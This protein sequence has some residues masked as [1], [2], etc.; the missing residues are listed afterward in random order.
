MSALNNN[1]NIAFAEPNFLVSVQGPNDPLDGN[2]HGTHVSGTIG[3][4]GNNSTGVAGVNW[5]VQLV[6]L[7]FLPD[8]GSGTLAGAIAA[9]DYY[10][11]I[12]SKQDAGPGNYVATN[13]SWGGGGFSQSVLDSMVRGARQDVLFVAAAGNGGSDLIGDSRGR[14]YDDGNAKTSG[15][16]DYALI[17]DFALGDKIQVAKGGTYLFH[18]ISLKT[19]PGTGLYFDSKGNGAFDT[20]DEL[21]AVIQ[22]PQ[23]SN[24]NGLRPYLCV[25]LGIRKG[26][27][28]GLARSQIGLLKA[29]CLRDD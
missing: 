10:T 17:T 22:G 2:G 13:N 4:I 5:A 7:K 9:I 29:A 18:A 19:G 11:Q 14:F 21:I 6:A 26:L 16:S 25:M 23:C 1:P 12:A 20:R 3:A 27:G 15:T 24:N 28:S 8:S